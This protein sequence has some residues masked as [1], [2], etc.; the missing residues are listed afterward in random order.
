MTGVAGLAAGAMS[1]AAGEYVSVY[2][3]A[4]IEN[5]DLAIERIELQKNPAAELRELENIYVARGK[6]VNWPGR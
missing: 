4:D 5:A 6:R 2:S 3:Q 1:M